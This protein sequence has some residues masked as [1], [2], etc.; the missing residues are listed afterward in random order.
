MSTLLHI[1]PESDWHGAKARGEY[2]ADS[3]ATEGFIHCS[4]PEQVI[5]T[6]GL[7]FRG[8]TGL[9]LLVIDPERVA[10]EIKYEDAGGVFF[11]HV[12]GPLELDAVTKVV[13]FPPDADG[14]FSLPVVV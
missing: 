2:R 7:F 4:T 12:Y 5:G 11:P 6:A 8:R 9:V 14:T 10:A 13:P 3:L 1:C